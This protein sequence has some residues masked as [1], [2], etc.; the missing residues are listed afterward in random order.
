[1]RP[2]ITGNPQIDFSS[3]AEPTA[4]VAW[5]PLGIQVSR[6]SLHI[7]KKRK[8][9]PEDWVCVHTE[10]VPFISDQTE[11]NL[12]F[13]V[14]ELANSEDYFEYEVAV[15]AERADQERIFS[16]RTGMSIVKGK[17]HC[18]LPITRVKYSQRCCTSLVCS[19]CLY[20]WPIT[21][22]LVCQ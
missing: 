5:K 12:D 17:N 10:H 22:L 14:P 11:Q 16:D 3:A 4:T 1:M 15:E 13:P 9:H 2:R 7:Y 6:Y 18:V 21:A 8:N 20:N 19:C